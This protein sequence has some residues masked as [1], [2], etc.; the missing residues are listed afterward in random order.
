MQHGSKIGV[1][2]NP[3]A[4]AHAGTREGSTVSGN[5]KEKVKEKRKEFQCVAIMPQWVGVTQM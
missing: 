5:G 3:H 1:E 2:R 4:W